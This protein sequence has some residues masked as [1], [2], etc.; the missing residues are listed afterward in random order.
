MRAL[1]F[2]ASTNRAFA[3][4]C[5][6]ALLA[7]TFLIVVEIFARRLFG[8][9]LQGVDEI[10]G[11][12]VAI[13]GTF[14]FAYGLIERS[15]TRIDIVLNKLPGRGRAALNALAMVMVTGAAVF[16]TWYGYKALA[17]SLTFNSRAATPLQTP[18][19]IPQSL[20]LAGLVMF[21]VTA[22]ALAL[23]ALVLAWRDPAGTNRAYG[24]SS[25]EEEV[26]RE[27]A[28]A[29]RRAARAARP[30]VPR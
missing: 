11:Y 15:H 13:T 14:G 17:D 26:E 8:F 2:I 22:A 20:W 23:H 12:V 28:D 9:S 21:S 6:Y 25:V 24:P 4:V 27:L 16:M 3:Y 10:G 5:G 18:T 30:E 19:W 29:S 1:N 7:L